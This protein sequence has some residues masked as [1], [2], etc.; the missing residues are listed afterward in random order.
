M[1]DGIT[2]DFGVYR[3]RP[4]RSTGNKQKWF[5]SI[6]NP[7]RRIGTGWDVGFYW[8]QT[9]ACLEGNE[10]SL[11]APPKCGWQLDDEG[12]SPA[13]VI[14]IEEEKKMIVKMKRKS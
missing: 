7:K 14:I 1:I 13:P 8:S 12:K 10:K 11:E 2:Y 5:I 4:S 9:P 3:C 6:V